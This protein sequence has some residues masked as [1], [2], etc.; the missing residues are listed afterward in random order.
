MCTPRSAGGGSDLFSPNFPGGTKKYSTFR[1]GYLV[2]VGVNYFRWD[3]GLYT[4]TMSISNLDF[5]L[6]FF[7]ESHFL[8]IWRCWNA[9]TFLSRQPCLFFATAPVQCL[10]KPKLILYVKVICPHLFI[11][12]ERSIKRKRTLKNEKVRTNNITLIVVI[13]P[14]LF[15]EKVWMNNYFVILYLSDTVYC[16]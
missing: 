4:C 16:A 7:L 5:D 15:V 14:H 3:L 12:Q 1:W 8:V 10:L 11:F 2:M 6:F 9:K 13:H